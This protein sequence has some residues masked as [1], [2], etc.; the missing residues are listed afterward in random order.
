M[1]LLLLEITDKLEADDFRRGFLF[2][3]YSFL[4]AFTGLLFNQQNY[5][6]LGSYV[7]I[8]FTLIQNS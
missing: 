8:G 1:V 6:G 2:L 4:E 3:F 7:R 5:K